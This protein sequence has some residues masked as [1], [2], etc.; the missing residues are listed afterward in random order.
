M[1]HFVGGAERVKKPSYTLWKN[2]ASTNIPLCVLH[3]TF[4]YFLYECWLIF[5]LYSSLMYSLPVAWGDVITCSSQRHGLW[6]TCQ[7]INRLSAVNCA[8]C[9]PAPDSFISTPPLT[10]QWLDGINV[11]LTITVNRSHTTTGLYYKAG[12]CLMQGE[13]LVFLTMKTGWLG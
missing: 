13:S 1:M 4:I 5:F 11:N 12:F 2:Q 9:M 8:I 7:N 10:P 6:Q 3:R